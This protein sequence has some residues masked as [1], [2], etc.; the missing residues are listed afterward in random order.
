MIFM[1]ILGLIS[2]LAI[3]CRDKPPWLPGK[4]YPQW[5]TPTMADVKTSRLIFLSIFFFLFSSPCT[6]GENAWS[7]TGY[8]KST[9]IGQKFALNTTKPPLK[10]DKKY[11]M[12]QNKLRLRIFYEPSSF[13][14]FEAAY[15]TAPIAA[16]PHIMASQGF[17]N[18][19][20]SAFRLND[21]DGEL[22]R[23]DNSDIS[24]F[25]NLD[26]FNLNFSFSFADLNIGRQAIAFGSGKSINP[27]D[28]FSPFVFQDLNKEEK[29]GV[30]AFRLRIP[31]G[32]MSEID[33]GL[34]M[35]ENGKKE[36]SALYL[37]TRL[38]FHNTDI[39][40]ITMDFQDNLMLGFD[41]TRAISNA[42][43]WLEGAHVFA[44]IFNDHIKEEDY[45]SLVS[46]LDYNFEN[47]TYIFME[48]HYNSAGTSIKKE[49]ISNT[50]RQNNTFTGSTT[51]KTAYGA[52]AAYL[53]GRH[54]LIPGVTYEFTPLISGTL[55]SLINL[56]DFSTYLGIK[57]EYNVKENLFLEAGVFSALGK[58]SAM[59][60]LT[61]IP[62]SEFGLYADMIYMGIRL[63]F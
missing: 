30:D 5:G 50:T 57:S 16:D 31:T 49:Y 36:N 55:H 6:A 41:M 40:M 21:L 18:P 43:F 29:T 32:D 59:E 4:G 34:V 63:Y 12:L 10:D 24:W 15:E 44:G 2:I 48:Y 20:T 42:G 11:V 46:G 26:R 13:F 9:I 33:L 25:H 27:T 23:R 60:G 8:L 39:S 17:V 28:I 1:L 7:I 56:S 54:Y 35:G 14:S 62:E 22:F 47:N 53:L 3:I 58:S 51:L 61:V 45:F 19:E 38:Y 52:G 37:R